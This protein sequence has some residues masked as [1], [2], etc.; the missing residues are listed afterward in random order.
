[1][2]VAGLDPVLGPRQ[3]QLDRVTQ[4]AITAHAFVGRDDQ[5]PIGER[6]VAGEDQ[7]HLFVAL[8]ESAELVLGPW[9]SGGM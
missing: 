1:M 6:R 8:A 4:V 7:T 5:G 3:L 2:I 9:R